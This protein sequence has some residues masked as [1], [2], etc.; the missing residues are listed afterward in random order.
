VTVTRQLL[1]SGA[2]I[3]P[4]MRI[5]PVPL[6]VESYLAEALESAGGTM[7]PPIEATVAPRAN[8]AATS[9]G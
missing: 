1:C 7:R 5:A 3:V 8:P 9:E 6:G 4:V 2:S